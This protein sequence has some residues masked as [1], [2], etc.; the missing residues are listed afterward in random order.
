VPDS[1]KESKINEPLINW[2]SIDGDYALEAIKK[3]GGWADDAT[4]KE[5]LLYAK[6]IRE[7]E[8]I[9]VIPASTAGLI[10]LLNHHKMEAIPNDK[11]VVI[12]TGRR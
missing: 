12:I 10:A 1:I 11:F 7:K 2:H 9:S 6:I 4:D 3:T 5:M 8:G